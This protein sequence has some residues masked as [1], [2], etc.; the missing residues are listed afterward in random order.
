MEPAFLC[1][2]QRGISEFG[3]RGEL[4]PEAGYLHL[5]PF[6]YFYSRVQ[7]FGYPT[8]MVRT[9]AEIPTETSPQIKVVSFCHVFVCETIESCYDVARRWQPL[10]Q[11]WAP[12]H[13]VAVQQMGCRPCISTAVCSWCLLPLLSPPQMLG[14]AFCNLARHPG[15][16]WSFDENGC[17][18]AKIQGVFKWK[19]WPWKS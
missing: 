3:D 4:G 2:L 1:F 18:Q 6:M 19:V 8:G 12:L 5:F 7:Y 9:S 13:R 10:F 15:F 14:F 17:T 16:N 11:P